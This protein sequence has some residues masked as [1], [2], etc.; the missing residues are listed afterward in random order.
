MALKRRLATRA[1]KVAACLPLTRPSPDWL[2]EVL[3]QALRPIAEVA[4][5]PARAG[6]D[7][8]SARISRGRDLLAGRRSIAGRAGWDGG[9]QRGARSAALANEVD[10]G[11]VVAA[12]SR[13]DRTLE[14]LAHASSSPARTWSST[15]ASAR[16]AL[17][18][19]VRPA[20][21]ISTMCRR[22]S[23]TSRRRSSSD[24]RSSS[25]SRPTRFV[26]S[27]WRASP[28]A[29][30]VIAP[31][32]R[33]IVSATRWRGRSPVGSRAASELRRAARARWL[34]MTSGRHQSRRAPRPD[35]G[36]G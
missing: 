1:C 35:R 12:V 20:S 36:R 11:K 30:W 15:D 26:G 14:T 4:R 18:R 8:W 33:R 7:D 16:S 34:S 5:E 29:T 2:A 13:V 28:S 25:L 27:R 23:R 10:C 32:S 17:V 24:S 21:E 6:P 19:A 3:R 31:R 22:R 9:Y